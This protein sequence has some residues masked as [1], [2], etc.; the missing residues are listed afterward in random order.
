MCDA[1]FTADY[2]RPYLKMQV[3][4]KA[5]LARFGKLSSRSFILAHFGI[6]GTKVLRKRGF[7]FWKHAREKV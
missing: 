2:K 5:G 1:F 4:L 3:E 6:F 7:A